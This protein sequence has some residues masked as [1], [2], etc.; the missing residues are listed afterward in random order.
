MCTSELSS[1][2]LNVFVNAVNT[3]KKLNVED[4]RFKVLSLTSVLPYL[5]FMGAV[6][7]VDS[8]NVTRETFS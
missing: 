6:F 7:N 8:T 1:V 2:N 5:C 4:F 3:K